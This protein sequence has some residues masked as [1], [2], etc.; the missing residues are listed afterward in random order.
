[1]VIENK[2][3]L[4]RFL[5][6]IILITLILSL[7]YLFNLQTCSQN[8]TALRKLPSM[9]RKDSDILEAIETPDESHMI[10]ESV[11]NKDIAG[12]TLM[13]SEIM[14]NTIQKIKQDL[15]E[16]PPPI[17][18]SGSQFMLSPI[19]KFPHPSLFKS[20]EQIL[21]AMW[22]KS[23]QEFLKKIHPSKRVTIT[24]A[25]YD[26]VENLLN[27]LISA[28]VVSKPPLRNVLVLCFDEQLFR[29]LAKK[30]VN[31]LYVPYYSV[32]KNPQLAIGNIW[33]T[34]MA[35]IRLLNH[36]GYHVRH[37][38]SDAV[39]L[40]NP[41]PLFAKFNSSDIIG[42]WG[43]YPDELGKNGPWKTTLCFGAA[44]FRSSV[45]TGR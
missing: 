37:F 39:I 27:W 8:Q 38:D 13:T 12:N 25:T 35:V 26:F 19:F 16:N 17:L 6:Y 9:R 3:N 45:K 23:L 33:L 32:L 15:H 30:G 43:D 5:L 28:H 7:G 4:I 41:E 22:P 1:M 40:K 18:A 24:M 2:L 11:I 42:S 34:R 36:W 31:A 10:Q 20:K 14:Q 21:N 29:F 44:L